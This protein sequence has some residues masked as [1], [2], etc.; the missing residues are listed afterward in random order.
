MK[1]V[2]WDLEIA[3]EEIAGGGRPVCVRFGLQH[4]RKHVTQIDGTDKVTDTPVVLDLTELH[5][6][7]EGQHGDMQIPSTHVN[8]IDILFK[9]T[10]YDR[11][12]SPRVYDP[13]CAILLIYVI[14]ISVV[15][16]P[17]QMSF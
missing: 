14:S 16:T 5:E 8:V 4:S 11:L 17:Y 12:Y 7:L 3:S 10:L 15:F 9:Q 1:M 13:A 6:I 2:N